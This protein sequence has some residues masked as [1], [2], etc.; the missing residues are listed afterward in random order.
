MEDRK[1][2]LESRTRRVEE[3]VYQRERSSLVRGDVHGGLLVGYGHGIE[4]TMFNAV[5]RFLLDFLVS[6]A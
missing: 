1:R 5:P 4:A 6:I 3:D 2:I